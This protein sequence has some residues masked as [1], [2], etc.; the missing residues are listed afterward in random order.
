MM[1]T[2]LSYSK[3]VPKV[4]QNFWNPLKKIVLAVSFLLVP[5]YGLNTT[6]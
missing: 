2:A 3:F 5:F 4:L 1:L 6:I